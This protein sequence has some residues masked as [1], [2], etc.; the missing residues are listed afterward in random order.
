MLLRMHGLTNR[1]C[2]QFNTEQLACAKH[3]HI[4]VHRVLL[5][6]SIV[7]RCAQ[8]ATATFPELDAM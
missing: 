3:K 2:E 5:L 1:I 4:S 6:V 8:A 7:L